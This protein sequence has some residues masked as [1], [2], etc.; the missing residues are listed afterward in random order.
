[1]GRPPGVGHSFCPFTG[2]SSSFPT[3]S[4]GAPPSLDFAVESVWWISKPTFTE[5]GMVL[6]PLNQPASGSA[7][8]GPRKSL[9]LY[10]SV[11]SSVKWEHFKAPSF[12]AIAGIEA[13]IL[14]KH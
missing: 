6:T 11:P 7:L 1:M 8:F 9:S 12:G 14:G 2:A 5:G 13:Q 10:C 3:P 4:S